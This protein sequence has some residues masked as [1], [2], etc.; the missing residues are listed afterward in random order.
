MRVYKSFAYLSIYSC[1]NLVPAMHATESLQSLHNPFPRSVDVQGGLQQ[2]WDSADQMRLSFRD[3]AHAIAHSLGALSTIGT[4]EYADSILLPA[5]EQGQPRLHNRAVISRNGHNHQLLITEPVDGRA[6]A[7]TYLFHGIT[8]DPT[9]AG[10][11]ILHS[12]VAEAIPDQK[13]VSLHSESVGALETQLSPRQAATRS[14]HNMSQARGEIG[15]VLFGDKPVHNV[16]MSMGTVHAV[17]MAYHNQSKG[18]MNLET[19]SLLSPAIITPDRARYVMAR[20]FLP[21]VF[22]EQCD[23]TQGVIRRYQTA[24]RE[25]RQLPA[26]CVSNALYLSLGTE[27]A[28]LMD[29]SGS[30]KVGISYGTEDPLAQPELYEMAAAAHPQNVRIFPHAGGHSIVPRIDSVLNDIRTNRQSGADTQ[31]LSMV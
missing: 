15:Q 12:K 22:D 1:G 27:A 16:S 14:F 24:Y 5:T 2:L 7:S 4:V 10:A 26:A 13:I 18:Y 3:K 25:L 8:Q 20:K 29:V 28:M 30:Y 21:S 6:V 23:S 19:L 17:N 11:A 9:K 31:P